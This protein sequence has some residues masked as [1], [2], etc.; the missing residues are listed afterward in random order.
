MSFAQWCIFILTYLYDCNGTCV[1]R[2]LSRYNKK[3]LPKVEATV[4]QLFS[5]LL[6]EIF[7]NVLI[8]CA[9]KRWEVI[10]MSRS[11]KYDFTKKIQFFDS[12]L[13]TT[14]LRL[15]T[16]HYTKQ[17]VIVIYT[18]FFSFL[19]IGKGI[20]H[21]GNGGASV[22]NKHGRRRYTFYYVFIW[23]Q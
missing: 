4:V 10:D 14:N 20:Y 6:Y 18:I 11:G 12:V 17:R 16:I 15:F 23:I 22:H 9:F 19:V 8:S 13:Q 2:S 1:N 3:R 7:T 21:R 5:H